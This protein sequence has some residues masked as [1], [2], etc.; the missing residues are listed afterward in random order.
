M[1]THRALTLKSFDT[2]VSLETGPQPTAD[3]SPVVVR[4]LA[5]ALEPFAREVFDGSRGYNLT[6]PLAPNP[7]AIGRV[8]EV[9]PDATKLAPGQLV[10]CVPTIH[11]RDNPE[12]QILLSLHAGMTLAS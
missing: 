5:V 3:T 8:E 6:F 1:T 7:N 4:V 9:D 2:L 12:V 11:G 10:I